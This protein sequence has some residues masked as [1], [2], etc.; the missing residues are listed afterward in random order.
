M[1]GLRAP[2]VSHLKPQTSRDNRLRWPPDVLEIIWQKVT[3]GLTAAQ[4][5]AH[6]TTSKRR[7]AS[8]N[9]VQAV[10]QRQKGKPGWPAH[11][12]R[13]KVNVVPRAMRKSSE[14]SFVTKTTPEGAAYDAA[15]LRLPLA[16]VA[17]DGCRFPV[18]D[19]PTGAGILFCGRPIHAKRYCEHHHARAYRCAE[20]E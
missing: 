6:L 7:P 5:A 14:Q 16:D 10:I 8:R 2:A 4:I 20:A 11:D 9:A 17:A 3:N 15:S 19:A 1:I 12:R 18:N 13:D